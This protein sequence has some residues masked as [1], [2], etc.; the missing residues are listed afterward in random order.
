MSDCWKIAVTSED[1]NAELFNQAI[2][3]LKKRF[4]KTM[5]KLKAR[6]NE[7]EELF[8]QWVDVNDL[9]NDAV[10]GSYDQAVL[11]FLMLD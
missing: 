6:G 9:F 7:L 3:N 8:S 11:A 4:R 2:R 10:N 5:K 1:E